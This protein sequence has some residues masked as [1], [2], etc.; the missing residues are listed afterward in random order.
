MMQRS[1]VQVISFAVLLALVLGAFAMVQPTESQATLVV[2]A[3]QAVVNQ[4]E[5]IVFAT[6]SNSAVSAGEAATVR[7]GDTIHLSETAT[8]QLRLQD[9]SAIDLEAGTVLTV[10]ELVTN[11]DSFRARFSQLAGKTFSQVVHLL[12]PDDAFEIRTPSST[13]S[14]RGTKFTVEV[15]SEEA[16]HFSVTEGVVQVTMGEQMVEVAA[17]YQVTAVVGQMLQ[18][19]PFVPTNNLPP[20]NT[21]ETNTPLP[22][23]TPAPLT[24]SDELPTVSETAVAAEESSQPQAGDIVDEPSSQIPETTT[25]NPTTND[26]NG[27]PESPNASST[28]NTPGEPTLPGNPNGGQTPA[29]A[30]TG[31]QATPTTNTPGLSP[32]NTATP[33]PTSTSVTPS[34]NTP[35]PQPTNL[36]V[37][38]PTSTSAP[39]PTNT[40]APAPTSTP[41]SGGKVTLCHNGNTI[42]VDASAVDAHLNHGDTLGPCP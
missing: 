11:D 19:I 41:D 34:S 26:T 24:V 36:P 28:P 4:N 33:P 5:T 14:V 35:T 29:S 27:V 9:G 18:V 38:P 21:N 22:T 2:S 10:S 37:V 7:Q 42:E 23:A 39:A 12:K 1:G 30:P 40:P 15:Q 8:A 16:T 3:G 13:A 25:N 6:V 20:S 17:G 32:T 31:T